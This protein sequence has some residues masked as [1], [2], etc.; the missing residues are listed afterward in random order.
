MHV[1]QAQLAARTRACGELEAQCA[2][3]AE[4]VADMLREAQVDP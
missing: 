1:T 4:R 3:L 2:G